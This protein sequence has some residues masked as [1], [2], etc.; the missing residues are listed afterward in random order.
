MQSGQGRSNSLGLSFEFFPPRSEK[1]QR[2][3]WRAVGRLE[4]LSPDFFS[5]TY[6][7]L[8]SGQSQS[9][10]TVS[11]LCQ[12]S[13]V[14]VVAHLTCFGATRDELN[15]TIDTFVDDYS[16]AGFVALRGDGDDPLAPY[17]PPEGGYQT[18]PE[19]VQYLRS[20]GDLAIHVAAYPE[21]HPQAQSAEKDLEHLK[22]K[23]DAG[24]DQAI[25]QYFFD[26][27]VFLRFRDAAVKIG[28]DKPIVPGILPIHSYDRVVKF[29][30]RCGASVPDFLGERYTA[31]GDDKL[32]AYR[33]SVELGVELCQRLMSEGVD[34]L[35]FYT[36]NETD[37]SHA[38]CQELITPAT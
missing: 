32:A 10:S 16:V 6:G 27:E 21:V 22:R 34:Q 36:L 28:I 1:M 26:P 24:A 5:V 2:K 25:T 33:L 14:P 19:L 38:I 8:G 35:H 3:F 12:E 29:S 30:E 11:E 4:A 23:L 15:R 37:L 20:Q 13:R 7:A 17:Q 9:M 18:V 31:L